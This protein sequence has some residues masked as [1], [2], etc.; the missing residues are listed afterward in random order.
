MI[1][2]EGKYARLNPLLGRGHRFLQAVAA[3]A[4]SAFKVLIWVKSPSIL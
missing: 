2:I 4:V 1:N 3:C